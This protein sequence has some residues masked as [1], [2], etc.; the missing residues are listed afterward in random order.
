MLEM[1]NNETPYE[2]RALKNPRTNIRLL[3][4]LADNID[5]PISSKLQETS[6]KDAPEYIALSYVWGKVEMSKNLQIDKRNKSIQPNV[7]SALRRFRETMGT[8]TIW[9]DAICID[10]NDLDERSAQ[11]SIMRDIYGSASC[12]FVYLGENH[13]SQQLQ[14]LLDSLKD[15]IFSYPRSGFTQMD[16][17]KLSEYGLPSITSESWQQLVQF[18]EHPWFSRVWVYQESL[19][20]K[21][22]I[23][24]QGDCHIDQIDLFAMLHELVFIRGFANAVDRTPRMNPSP[25]AIAAQRCSS[26][27]FAHE[28]LV[29]PV[30]QNWT[31]WPL[32]KLLR[33]NMASQA[34]DP[35]DHVFALLGVSEEAMEP[36]LQ[37]DYKK[38]VE[39][40]YK[41]VGR[42]MAGKGLAYFLLACTT[43]HSIPNWPSWIP[44]WHEVGVHTLD[45]E[46]TFTAAGQSIQGFQCQANYTL[47]T[48]GIIV[49]TIV[50]RGSSGIRID[51]LERLESPGS[52]ENTVL[53]GITE[54]FF[55]LLPLFPYATGES[56]ATILT[57]LSVCDCRL[58]KPQQAPVEY[59][60]GLARYLSLA[61]AN[62]H[63]RRHQ[64]ADHE[65]PYRVLA[66]MFDAMPELTS[67]NE[68]EDITWAREFEA[69]AFTRYGMH[70]RYATGKGYI[71]QTVPGAQIGDRV[72][73]LRGC[74]VP[75]ILRPTADDGYTFVDTCYLHGIMHGEAWKEE[76]IC[77]IKIV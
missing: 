35:R 58:G 29:A 2:H 1:A 20:A 46:R 50:F 59:Q 72:A 5:A 30:S 7:F 36:E 24:I 45:P 16:W 41:R 38:G 12:V 76:G 31:R 27:L 15:F 40:V 64:D 70:I 37:P 53:K 26:I 71:G 9:I 22:A 48:Q 65:L 11:V 74:N 77:T 67:F 10:Q 42:Y 47:L 6:L 51:S 32:I 43:S 56:M 14:N 44:R 8:F 66:M 19:V 21:K 25:M 68:V 61:K 62:L 69:A 75:L 34:T 3:T 28:P 13:Q 60:Q 49:D 63:L 55:M 73:L 39:E 23:F 33:A 52:Q 57:R 18:L 54:A 17:G 4:V